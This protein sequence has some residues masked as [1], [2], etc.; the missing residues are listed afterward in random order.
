MARGELT[1]YPLL[2]RKW[3]LGFAAGSSG[4]LQW[5]WAREP[6]FGMKRS[7][8]SA[9]IWEPMMRDLGQFAKKAAP[10]ASDLLLP[11]VAIVLPQSLQLSTSNA[12]AL[13]SQQK[14]V[15]ALYYYARAEAYAVGEY[16]IELIG[17]PKLI[18]VPSSYTL[19]QKAWQT[20]LDRA[21]AGATVLLS[22]PFDKDAHFHPTARQTEVGLD[23]DTGPLTARENVL[24]WPGGQSQLT[25]SGEKT[26]YLDRA[27]M[28]GGST[29]TEGKIGKGKVMFSALPLELNDNQCR[30]LEMSTATC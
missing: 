11:Q 10:S 21:K 29:W 26:T 19:S 27:F 28:P 25:Y 3:V 22:G 2:E 7:D 23:F 5:D 1:G 16:Q 18:I 12:F 6:D 13:E 24:D 30:A 9:K 14:C 15:R 4:A 17:N 20:L 8:G